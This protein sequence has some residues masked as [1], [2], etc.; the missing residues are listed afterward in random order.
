MSAASARV[1]ARIIAAATAAG[2]T[3]AL[4][5]CVSALRLRAAPPASGPDD[6]VTGPDNGLA[7]TGGSAYA[8]GGL[9]GGSVLAA[10]G[11]TLLLRRRV[12]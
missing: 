9:T 10:A 5:G 12:T 1:V 7:D 6:G 8:L 3:L 2:G 11:V 4:L